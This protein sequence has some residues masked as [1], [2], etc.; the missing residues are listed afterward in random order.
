MN[1]IN[2]DEL[3]KFV[4]DIRDF[5]RSTNVFLEQVDTVIEQENVVNAKLN[6]VHEFVSDVKYIDEEDSRIEAQ[7]KA[8]DEKN[9]ILMSIQN[10]NMAKTNEIDQAYQQKKQVINKIYDKIRAIQAIINSVR[11]DNSRIPMNKFI[12]FI[13]DTES[14]IDVV[15]AIQPISILPLDFAILEQS[16]FVYTG[17]H[18]MDILVQFEVVSTN[19][20]PLDYVSQFKITHS[21]KDTYTLSGVTNTVRIPM[22]INEFITISSN[23]IDTTFVKSLVVSIA[24]EV[25][26]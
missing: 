23:T 17:K 1:D 11:L 16:K 14:P 15:L 9:N 19:M 3:Y 7:K 26:T 13:S 21:N 22:R 12:L 25:S 5:Y 24:F 4:N 18:R 8:I 10:E 20:S 6:Q 2:I